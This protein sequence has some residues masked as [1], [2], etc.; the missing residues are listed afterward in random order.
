MK[1][2]LAHREILAS[3]ER[4]LNAYIENVVAEYLQRKK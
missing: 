3:R 1:M 2:E 4:F